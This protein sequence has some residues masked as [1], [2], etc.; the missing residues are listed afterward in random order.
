[1]PAVCQT[2]FLFKVIG[3]LSQSMIYSCSSNYGSPVSSQT[4][5]AAWHF[6]ISRCGLEDICLWVVA[7]LTT[8]FLV[9]VINQTWRQHAAHV[10]SLSLFLMVLLKTLAWSYM[11]TSVLCGNGTHSQGL[12]T[13]H[14]SIC[15]GHG[16]ED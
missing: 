5:R 3:I 16:L 13:G 11:L 12:M 9:N 6:A 15:L 2:V 8:W 10:L 7:L 4:R 14:F 1:M